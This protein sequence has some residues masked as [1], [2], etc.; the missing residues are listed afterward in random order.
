MADKKVTIKI[1][2]MEV[3]R[4][5]TEEMIETQKKRRA[6]LG[7]P[8]NEG[9]KPDPEPD[10][11]PEP[12]PDKPDGGDGGEGGGEVAAVKKTRSRKKPA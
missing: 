7:V 10:P 6:A 9:G 12:E 3:E 5:Y 4:T 11:E 1:G 2:G 8:I